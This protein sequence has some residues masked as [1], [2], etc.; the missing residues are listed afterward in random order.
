[1]MVL[2]PI[3]LPLPIAPGPGTTTWAVASKRPSGLDGVRPSPPGYGIWIWHRSS[4]P[5]D[6]AGL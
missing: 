3:V 6:A 1:M 5:P 2:C 4:D